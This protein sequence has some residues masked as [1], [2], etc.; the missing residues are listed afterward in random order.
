MHGQATAM[1]VLGQEGKIAPEDLETRAISHSARDWA[2]AAAPVLKCNTSEQEQH[3][4]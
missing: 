2:D 3:A 4:A 1:Q